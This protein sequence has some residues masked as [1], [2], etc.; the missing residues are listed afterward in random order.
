MTD[1]QWAIIGDRLLKGESASSLAR[2]FGIAKSRISER[3]SQRTKTVKATAT[4]LAE[5]EIEMQA[6]SIPEQMMARNLADDLKAISFHLA[7]SAKYGAMNSH[8]LNYIANLQVQKID[9]IDPMSTAQHLHAVV[10]LTDGA[11]EASKT[12]INLIRANQDAV[13]RINKDTEDT[14][15]SKAPT[16]QVADGRK[17]A[18]A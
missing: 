18:D 10:S 5:A 15:A 13:N 8:R 3:F 17:N 14:P 4:K 2:E 11:N 16:F 9:E 12:G 7:G 6:L 1:A